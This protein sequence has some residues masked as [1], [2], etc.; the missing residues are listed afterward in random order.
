MK[1]KRERSGW[2]VMGPLLLLLAVGSVSVGGP[3]MVRGVQRGL[4]GSDRGEV[5]VMVPRGGPVF[6]P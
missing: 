5:P 4:P 2:L 3:A 1:R 6:Y